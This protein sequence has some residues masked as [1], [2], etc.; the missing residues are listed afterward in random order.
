MGMYKVYNSITFSPH[1]V[2]RGRDCCDSTQ[3]SVKRLLKSGVSRIKIPDKSQSM[4]RRKDLL[5][6]DIINTSIEMYT[7]WSESSPHKI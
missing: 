7:F 1:D 3:E 2:L 6:F 5:Q 4:S